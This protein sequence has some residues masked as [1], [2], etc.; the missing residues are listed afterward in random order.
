[1][2]V[3]YELYTSHYK[4]R[5]INII[6]IFFYLSE[7]YNRMTQHLLL[8]KNG[9]P[10]LHYMFSVFWQVPYLFISE[11]YRTCSSLK[12]SNYQK[13]NYI[14]IYIYTLFFWSWHKQ[15]IIKILKSSKGRKY[16]E[17]S[18]LKWINTFKQCI[19]VL[20]VQMFGLT[21]IVKQ[22]NH[23]N[24]KIYLILSNVQL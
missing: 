15:F 20:W 17:F 24:P 13:K 5:Y 22:S 12:Y 7:I 21:T 18:G 8:T 14:Y 6:T 9:M 19:R 10:L 4:Y 11:L 1:M 16:L 23:P 2:C 3:F